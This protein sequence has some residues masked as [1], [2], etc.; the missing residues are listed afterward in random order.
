MGPGATRSAARGALCIHPHT[1]P[2][3]P[4][5]SR[6]RPE[7]RARRRTTSQGARYL[8]AKLPSHRRRCSRAGQRCAQGSGHRGGSK[9]RAAPLGR[10]ARAGRAPLHSRLPK[11]KRASQPLAQKGR[12]ARAAAKTAQRTHLAELAQVAAEVG[13]PQVPADERGDGERAC[14]CKP[15]PATLASAQA[16]LLPRS[17]A[18]TRL[19]SG[20]RSSARAFPLPATGRRPRHA[21]LHRPGA[22]CPAVS[23]RPARPRKPN[24]GPKGLKAASPCPKQT[25]GYAIRSYCTHWQSC[26]NCRTLTLMLGAALKS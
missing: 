5:R 7:A 6:H 18:S 10:Q 26:R 25:R 16:C 12:R 15:R 11:E 9:L 8:A 3:V 4:H 23:P 22:P 2:C 1:L 19:P 13:A 21:C 14:T 24:Q 17:R 20:G